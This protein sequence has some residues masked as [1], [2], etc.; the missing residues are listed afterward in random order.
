M[1]PIAMVVVGATGERCRSG[2]WVCEGLG[3]DMDGNE[4]VGDRSR[5]SHWGDSVGLHVMAMTAAGRPERL[6]LW[7]A[8]SVSRV[9]LSS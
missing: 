1:S 2:E 4:N 9:H 8:W 5:F 3:K 7:M 6:S